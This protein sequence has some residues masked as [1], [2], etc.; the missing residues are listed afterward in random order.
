MELGSPIILVSAFGRG[1]WLAAALAGEGIKTTLV[2][3]TAKLGVWPSEDIEGPFG[4]FR[5]ERISD[6]QVE[7]LY[8]EDP[9]Q[10]ATNGFTLWL[11]EGPIEFKGPLTKFKIDNYEFAQP[12]KEILF[13]SEQEKNAKLAYKNL[14]EYDF[15]RSWLL[16]FAHQWAS[17]T[18]VP[19][20]QI[21][22]AHV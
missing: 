20:A 3:V 22:R 19:S 7:R 8:A 14:P 11:P 5:N 17:T 10:E 12:V 4:F 21:G 1:H 13:S 18:Y 15:D 6:S 9:F 2:D 16:H